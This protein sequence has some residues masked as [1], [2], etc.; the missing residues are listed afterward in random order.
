MHPLTALVFSDIHTYHRKINT[1]RMLDNLWHL[2]DTTYNKHHVDI[3]IIAGD[4][5]DR[6]CDLARYAVSKLT[7]WI[8]KLFN[9][10]AKYKKKVRVLEGTPLHDNKQSVVFKEV[11]ASMVS[12]CDFRYIDEIEIEYI[13]D[14]DAHVLYVP[15][16]ANPTA[17]LTLEKVKSILDA[18]NLRQVDIAVMHGLFEFQIPVITNCPKT[19]NSEVYLEIVKHFIFNGHDHTHKSYKRIIVQGSFDRLAHGEEGAKGFVIARMGHTDEPDSFSFIENTKATVFK[20]IN[21]LGLNLEDSINK[22]QRELAKIP[23]ESFVRIRVAKNNP[24]VESLGEITRSYPFIEFSKD[25]VDTTKVVETT[26][27]FQRHVAITLTKSNIVDAL[28]QR[29]RGKNIDDAIITRARAI[30]EETVNE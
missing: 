3:V 15:D 5:F 16:E 27:V 17:A 2:I 1:N 4:F 12:A 28:L 8:T 30:L 6:M 9:W 19:H 21:L 7:S 26:H 18:R 24:I 23:K 10:C 13:P 11:H 20:T 29:L 14:F 25:F 22:M